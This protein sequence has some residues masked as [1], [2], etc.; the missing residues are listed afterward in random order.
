MK[1]GSAAAEAELNLERSIWMTSNDYLKAGSM[2]YPVPHWYW[3]MQ[4]YP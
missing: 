3:C 2:L 4:I 1:V